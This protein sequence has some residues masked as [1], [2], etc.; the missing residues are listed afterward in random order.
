VDTFL[1]GKLAS[2]V[3]NTVIQDVKGGELGEDADVIADKMSGMIEEAL[4][5]KKLSRKTVR[6][7]FVIA[8]VIALACIVLAAISLAGP[9]PK[10]VAGLCA[11][12][13]GSTGIGGHALGIAASTK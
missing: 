4:G 10:W 7:V 3:A 5:K 1:E 9:L 12:I 13:V 6:W 2:D 8:I 11:L